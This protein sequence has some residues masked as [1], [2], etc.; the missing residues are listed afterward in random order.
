[1]PSARP[2]QDRRGCPVVAVRSLPPK[3]ER[4]VNNTE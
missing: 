3:P 1:V 4:H 2:W